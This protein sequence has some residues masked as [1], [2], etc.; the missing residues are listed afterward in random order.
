VVLIRRP[1]PSEHD[2][3]RAL[4]QT[5]VDEVYGG[6]WASPPLHI[7]EEDWSLAWVAV[8]EFKMVGMV[9]TNEE[10]VSDLWVAREHRNAGLGRQLLSRGEREIAA[11]GHFTARLRV[12]KSNVRA[13]SFYDR[14]GWRVVR[15]F[16]HETLPVGML[17]MSK[18]LERP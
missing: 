7:D 1:R 12:V 17:E 11:R 16:P 18:A 9:L 2:A 6:V 13:V 14:L 10:W 15:E 4:V 8:S 3:V 5:V